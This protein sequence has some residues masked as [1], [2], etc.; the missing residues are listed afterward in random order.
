MLIFNFISD[1]HRRK[2]TLEVPLQNVYKNLCMTKFTKFEKQNF[3]ETLPLNNALLE[4]QYKTIC[5]SNTEYTKTPI[6]LICSRNNNHADT[7]NITVSDLTGQTILKLQKSVPALQFSGCTLKTYIQHIFIS[8]T[9]SNFNL[10]PIP[11]KKKKMKVKDMYQNPKKYLPFYQ[12]FII[13][14]TQ[15][16]LLNWLLFP[17]NFIQQC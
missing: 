3:I 6:I 1:L 13:Y 4:D 14:K 5:N 12:K 9:F 15:K 17:K 2:L 16:L 7:K 10:C 8:R 11:K